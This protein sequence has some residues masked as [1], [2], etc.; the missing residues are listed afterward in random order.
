MMPRRYID[1]LLVLASCLS[2]LASCASKSTRE[3]PLV[4]GPKAP[5]VS[6]VA[7]EL[8]GEPEVIDQDG[9]A[10]LLRWEGQT[11]AVWRSTQ[12]P[13]SEAFASYVE[14]IEAAGADLEEPV[15]DPPVIE[16]DFMREVWRR[17][18]LNEAMSRSGEGGTL[19]RAHCIEKL[20]YAYQAERFDALDH[21]TE[22]IVAKVTKEGDEG[23]M[24]R[25]YFGASSEMFPPKRF[26]PFDAAAKD[27]EA[28]WTFEFFLHNHTPRKLGDKPALGPPSP[29]INDVMLARS[30]A[31]SSRL[32]RVLVTN[33]FYTIDI[34]SEKLALYQIPPTREAEKP[35]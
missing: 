19:R 32:K 10:L 20:F 18:D 5:A 6:E 7:C 35:R 31:A 14:R 17:E 2:L 1:A 16:D 3:D 28:G 9:D 11:D 29:S 30:L 23:T 12:A 26:Y 25:F 34:P 4:D 27:V 22:F 15:A 8:P 21:P 24:A 33:G 13:S